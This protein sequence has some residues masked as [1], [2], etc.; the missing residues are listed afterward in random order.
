MFGCAKKFYFQMDSMLNVIY[1]KLRSTLDTSKQTGLKKEQKLWLAKRDT[2]FKKTFSE[3]KKK[4]PNNSP[5]GSAWGA[6][7]DAMFMY[8]DNAEF[9][10]SRVLILLRKLN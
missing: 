3:F 1:F 2:Y 4:N 9:I 10:K 6:Q 5:Y 8:N 7:D